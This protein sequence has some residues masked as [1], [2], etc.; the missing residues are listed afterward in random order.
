MSIPK[1]VEVAYKVKAYAEDDVMEVTR[2]LDLSNLSE[3]D[4]MSY[5]LDSIIIL[6]QA[7]DRRNATKKEGAIPIRATGTFKV[8]KSGSRG[9]VSAEAKLVKALGKE[10]AELAI[11]KFGSAEAALEA[12]KALIK[13]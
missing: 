10:T 3:D 1:T 5:A 4:I 8:N 7:S 11:T 12:L 6:S 2:I 13:E 9:T